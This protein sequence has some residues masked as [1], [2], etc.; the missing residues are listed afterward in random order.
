[1][2]VRKMIDQ[3]QLPMNPCT[4]LN[5]VSSGTA[6][7]LNVPKLI[8]RTSCGSTDC[9][10]SNCFGPTKNRASFGACGNRFRDRATASPPIARTSQS[11]LE[12]PVATAPAQRFVAAAGPSR[13]L[14]LFAPGCFEYEWTKDQRLAVTLLRSVGELSRGDLP[15]RPGHAA[16]PLPTPLAQEPG[17]HRIDLALAVGGDAEL[18][19]PAWLERSWENVFLPLQAVYFRSSTLAEGQ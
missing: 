4:H 14:A 16:W 12:Q 1:M 5:D 11:A 7:T 10:R 2:M 6:S 8:A 19:Q 15:E 9:R 13:G 3:P 17:D 18:A